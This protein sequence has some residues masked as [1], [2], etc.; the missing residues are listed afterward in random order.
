MFFLSTGKYKLIYNKNFFSK[1]Y[2]KITVKDKEA[3]KWNYALVKKINF[4]THPIKNF[5]DKI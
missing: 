2:Q 3:I 1:K 5:D 4:F